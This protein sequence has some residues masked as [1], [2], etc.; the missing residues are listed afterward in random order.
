MP[1]TQAGEL[2]S[3]LAPLPVEADDHPT[4]AQLIRQFN[5]THPLESILPRQGDYAN[6]P[7]QHHPSISYYPPD[8]THAC[9]YW[10]DH[11]GTHQHGDAFELSCL[12]SGRSKSEVL[13]DLRAEWIGQR[14][15]SDDQA[16]ASLSQPQSRSEADATRRGRYLLL[17]TERSYLVP[18]RRQRAR[19]IVVIR[20]PGD[21]VRQKSAT[22]A[23]P[24]RYEVSIPLRKP[25]PSRPQG[26]SYHRCILHTISASRNDGQQ[27]PRQ[28][29]R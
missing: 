16:T 14:C 25:T 27:Y 6:L 21:G 8:P 13:R 29:V 10:Y 4:V 1:P 24:A 2:S 11:G 9:A 18:I 26:G 3:S 23:E 17:Q 19:R 12:V 20:L 5:D 22:S 7:G 15:G 28:G